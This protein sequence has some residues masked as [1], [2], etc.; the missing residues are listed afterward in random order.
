MRTAFAHPY[1]TFIET[2]LPPIPSGGT[3]PRKVFRCTICG[4]MAHKGHNDA[5]V[6]ALGRVGAEQL[7]ICDGIQF[8]AT[9]KR[10]RAGA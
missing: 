10:R 9:R 2:D 3:N 7:A 5:H 4:M 6:V 1:H 8:R